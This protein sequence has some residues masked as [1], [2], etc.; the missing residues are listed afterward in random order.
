MLQGLSVGDTNYGK[1]KAFCPGFYQ[2][3][4]LP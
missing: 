3:G 4:L 1:A 2:F